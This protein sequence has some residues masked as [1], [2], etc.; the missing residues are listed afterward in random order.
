MNILKLMTREEFEIGIRQV[1]CADVIKQAAL[2]C[3]AEGI[4]ASEAER[5]FDV[6]RKDITRVLNRAEE[7]YLKTARLRR[8]TLYY[9]EDH[10]IALQVQTAKAGGRTLEVRELDR[11]STAKRGEKR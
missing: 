5:R 2:A 1:R 11:Y 7:E 3:F 6:S 9:P 10:L 4:S 8:V